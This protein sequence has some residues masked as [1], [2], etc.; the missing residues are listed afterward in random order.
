MTDD[1]PELGSVRWCKTCQE[2]W[3]DDEEFWQYYRLPAG[4]ITKTIRGR[5]YRR[6]NDSHVIRCRACYPGL[7][8]ERRAVHA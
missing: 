7:A 1:D 3:P 8:R 6:K 5:V 4:G 2:W